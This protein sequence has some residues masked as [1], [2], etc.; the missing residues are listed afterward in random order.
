[1]QLTEVMSSLFLLRILGAFTTWERVN[2]PQILSN[3]KLYFET[4]SLYTYLKTQI[5]NDNNKK[6]NYIVITDGCI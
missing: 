2:F 6:K 3:Y 5:K 4:L 1:M